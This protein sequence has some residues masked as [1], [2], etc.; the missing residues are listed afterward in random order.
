MEDQVSDAEDV[1]STAAHS[2]FSSF[3]SV[4]VDVVHHQD[5]AATM[6]AVV[7]MAAET[8]AVANQKLYIGNLE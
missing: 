7:T 4:A 5:A 2:S 1:V 3:S 8:S 6:P